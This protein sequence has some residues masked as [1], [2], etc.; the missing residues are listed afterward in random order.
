MLTPYEILQY[1][2]ISIP[3]DSSKSLSALSIE[4]YLPLNKMGQLKVTEQE[5]VNVTLRALWSSVA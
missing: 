1:Q 5:A 3:S 2:E 4:T